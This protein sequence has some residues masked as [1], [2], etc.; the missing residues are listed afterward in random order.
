MFAKYIG[1]EACSSYT[2]DSTKSKAV[3]YNLIQTYKL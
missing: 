1:V 3:F 2:A